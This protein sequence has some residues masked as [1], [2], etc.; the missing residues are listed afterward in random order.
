M[1]E[2]TITSIVVAVFC[3]KRGFDYRDK[4]VLC[5]P[6]VR[7][8]SCCHLNIFTRK[9]ALPGT[10][11]ATRSK[12]L[13][14]AGVVLAAVCAVSSGVV[15]MV[16]LQQRKERLV[17]ILGSLNHSMLIPQLENGRGAR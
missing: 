1:R 5:D 9:M 4:Q 2:F 12:R 11:L 16:H 13:Q 7:L 3:R 8:S 17:S 14:R 6:K 10:Q 15:I